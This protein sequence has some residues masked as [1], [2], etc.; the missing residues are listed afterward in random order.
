[1]A[2]I[3]FRSVPFCRAPVGNGSWE[4]FLAYGC[5][6]HGWG[7]G[8]GLRWGPGTQN[9]GW[10]AFDLVRSRRDGSSP[11]LGCALGAVFAVGGI[12]L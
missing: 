1:M 6:D 5:T 12:G 7:G 11:W 2:N 10:M 9:D 8:A 4:A 3:Q